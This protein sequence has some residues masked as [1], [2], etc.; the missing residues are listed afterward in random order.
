MKRLI[1]VWTLLIFAL[2]V[3][4]QTSKDVVKL[5]NGSVIKGTITQL[6]SAETVTITTSDGC[7]FVYPID[8]VLEIC[9]EDNAGTTSYVD[10]CMMA[11]ND[12]AEN[13]HGEGSL[14]GATWATT[15]VL[16]PILG[17][18]PAAVGASG[19]PSY[20][21]MNCPKPELYQDNMAYRHCYDKEAKKIKKRKSWESFGMATLTYIGMYALV[22]ISMGLSQIGG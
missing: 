4:A 14:R 1:L 7:V 15:I 12:A 3:G 22:V 6:K 16:S 18:I 13:Y 5:K 8:D 19:E 21:E 20:T 9:K 10:I 2:S 17:I 11:T